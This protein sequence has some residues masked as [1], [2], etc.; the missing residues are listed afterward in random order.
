MIDIH[1]HI[2][3]DVDDG[4]KNIEESIKMLYGAVE[5]G[6][7][8]IIFTSHAFHPQYHAEADIMKERTNILRE[9][10]KVHNIPLTI[11]T[12]H[13][14]RLNDHL[15]QQVEDG[16]ALTL[17]N[18]KY[19]L[20]ELPSREVPRY[21][22]DIVNQLVAKSIVPVIAHPERN[23][24]IMEKPE[25]LERL[26]FQGAISQVNAGSIAGYFG[27]RIQQ[28]SFSLIEA[29]LIHTYG[30]D[31]HNLSSRPFLFDKGLSILEKHKLT[32][33]VDIFLEN[34]ARIVANDNV[35]IL[36]PGNIPKKK[37]WGIFF[38]NRKNSS[39][40]LQFFSV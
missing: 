31:A 20:L 34:N 13:E 30:S 21:T 8:E 36:E 11:H 9:G 29:N 28:A 38:R 19:L 6:I 22:F 3:F 12:G 18:S 17:A 39:D 7:T 35:I 26:I 23:Y 24:G 27:K 40:I 33:F 32:D 2:V 14:V 37:W 15:C 10:L 5:E 1:S 4:A 25:L 16:S